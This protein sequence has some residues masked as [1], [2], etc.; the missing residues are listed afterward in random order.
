MLEDGPLF[1]AATAQPE[2]PVATGKVWSVSELSAQIK[3]SLEKGFAKV[4]VQGELSGAKLHSS[5][6]F[7]CDIKDENAVLNAVA[8]RS[9]VARWPSVPA[10]GALVVATGRITTYPGRSTYQLM[11]D[12][13][14]PAGLG[15][16]MLQLEELK[17]KLTAEGLFDESRKRP[18]PLLPRRI[19]IITSPTGAVIRDMLHRL[20]ER[21]PR[22]V[23]L[24]PVAVQGP[25]AADEVADA[26]EGF[27]SMPASQRPDVLIVARG[28]GSF[29]D[30][31][32]F[33]AE[34]LV[35]AVAAS[36]IPVISGVG[37]EPDF[38]LCDFAAD[39]RAPTPTAAAEK[40]VDFVRGQMLAHLDETCRYMAQS[41]RGQLDRWLDRVETARRLL[42][43]PLRMVLQATQRVD[44]LEERVVRVGG[45]LVPMAQQKL[46]GLSRVLAAHDPRMPL[47]R[48]YVYLTRKGAML[49]NVDAPAGDVRIHFAKGRTREGVLK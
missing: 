11:L 45:M 30:L 23:I 33:N 22:E 14:E 26:I 46:E 19:G 37:H 41:L 16:L 5:G 12:K 20:A 8:W 44:E 42:P 38:T 13:L 35:R 1:A 18:L 25:T 24:W 48:G 4:V 49:R 21:C 6:H 32:P 10:N 43:D 9:T 7:Y 31:M 15:A 47:E 34:V 36:A 39:L 28:G 2:A 40:V 27:N 17:R 3:S 29:E